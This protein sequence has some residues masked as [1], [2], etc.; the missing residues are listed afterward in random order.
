M[1]KKPEDQG[2]KLLWRI[3]GKRQKE[4]NIVHWSVFK[5]VAIWYILYGHVSLE[6]QSLGYYACMYRELSGCFKHHF[7]SEKKL[8]SPTE[9]N[10]VQEP[11]KAHGPGSAFPT[12]FPDF[13]GT[14]SRKTGYTGRPTTLWEFKSVTVSVK[15][16]W[17]PSSDRDEPDCT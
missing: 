8:V 10:S 7:F 9:D 15:H 4:Q 14:L 1:L 6:G 11:F 3:A 16:P 5:V 2:S 12:A 17:S 13:T